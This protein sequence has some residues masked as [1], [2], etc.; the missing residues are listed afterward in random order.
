MTLRPGVKEDFPLLRRSVHG[1]PIVYLDTAASSQK[2]RFVLEA[3]NDYYAAINANVH[4]G[5]YEI[6]ALATEGMEAGRRRVATFV[7]ASTPDEIVF[8][9]NATEA[10]NLVARS[11]GGANLGPGDAVLI[12]EMEH[13]ADIVPWQILAAEKGFEIRWIPL[14]GDGQLDLTDL[15]R[16]LDGVKIV[17]C[18]AM[19][20]VL[21][22]INPICRIADAAHA[23]GALLLADAS[24]FVPHLP[25]DVQAMGADF[26]AFT[27]HK[28]CG[29]TGIGVLW[30][31]AELLDAM[32]PFLGG[33]EMIL[34]V[35]KDGFTPNEIPHK[36]EA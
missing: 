27:G 13:H 34:D 36:F 29:P 4:R 5:A 18:T 25:T 20:N 17:G 9:K 19:S 11:W 7:N 1:R 35:R 6:A 3:M 16:L 33:G 26:V 15:D 2:P 31:R 12:T 21:G 23:T 14:T 8:T 22:T 28:M 10:M 24:Q 32:P 30:G